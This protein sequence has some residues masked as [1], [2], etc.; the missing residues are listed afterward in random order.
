MPKLQEVC[1]HIRSKNAGPFWITFDLFFTDGESYERY[2]SSPAL[3][4]KSIA[5]LFD[6]DPA[7]VRIFAIDLLGVVKISIPRR[8][9]QGGAVERDMHAGQQFIP[10]MDVKV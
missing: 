9:P 6:V 5:C 7:F 3:S 4:A 10:L 2:K 1:R 8:Q